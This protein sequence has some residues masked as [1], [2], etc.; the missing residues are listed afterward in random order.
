MLDV[1]HGMSNGQPVMKFLGQP[2]TGS[3]AGQTFSHNRAGQY[4]RNRRA[5]TQPIG[6]GRRGVIQ[7]L[8]R[9]IQR[10]GRTHLLTNRRLEFLRAGLP[11]GG[12]ARPKHQ[13][14]E[15]I[16]CSIAD[17]PSLKNAGGAT[18]SVPPVANASVAPAFTVF[19]LT[20]LGVLTL[21][22]AGTSFHGLHPDCVLPAGLRRRRLHENL[23]AQLVVPG[24]SVGAATYGTAYVA[25]FGL[26]TVGQRVFV[27]LTPVNQ[28]GVKGTPNIAFCTVT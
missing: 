23:L 10:V 5:P 8:F 19:T 13:A 28:Y 21:T 18:T 24:S 6:T 1:R 15:S 25:Q 7:T 3:M 2:S 11:P 16:L 4:I 20:H 27:R 14:D 26:P 22:L 17:Q 9:V 12:Q